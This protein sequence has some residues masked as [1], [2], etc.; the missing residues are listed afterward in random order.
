M[1]INYI[2]FQVNDWFD[3]LNVRVPTSDNRN[4]T[5]AYGLALELQENI[6]NTMSETMENM[7]V[8]GKKSL[9]PFQKG[10]NKATKKFVT[11]MVCSIFVFV[12]K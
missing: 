7:R 4:R 5:K 2:I 9:L 8:K 3:I 1:L 10:N 11:F 12:L 6:I